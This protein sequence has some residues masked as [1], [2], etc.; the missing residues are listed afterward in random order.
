[1]PQNYEQWKASSGQAGAGGYNQYLAQNQPAP[2]APAPQPPPGGGNNAVQ[3]AAN[4]AQAIPRQHQG[5]GDIPR[6]IAGPAAA[7]T[8]IPYAGR[9]LGAIAQNPARAAQGA[10][11]PMAAL[12]GIPFA[13]NIARAFGFGGNPY[14]TRQA[15]QERQRQGQAADY[16]REEAARQG[17]IS[18]QPSYGDWASQN[19]AAG[20][21]GLQSVYDDWQSGIGD[22]VNANRALNPD[23]SQQGGP[24]NQN[25]PLAQL[26][27]G[28]QNS[29]SQNSLLQ[30]IL[31]RAQS[32][33]SRWGGG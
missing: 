17:I 31:Q 16:S 7:I 1:M 18:G 28:G 15:Q 27:Q 20:G 19:Q 9:A 12:T 10:A 14:H 23:P 4:F 2:Q 33:S 29:L 30:A 8:G 21:Q 26:L 11:G 3:N 5:A 25:S 13:G 6:N 24:V 22:Q 32:G